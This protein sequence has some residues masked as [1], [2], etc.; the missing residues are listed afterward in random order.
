M[1]TGRVVLVCG[2]RG[3]DDRD[4]VF[5]VLDGLHASDPIGLLRHGDAP[6]ADALADEWARRRGVRRDPVP[7]EWDR[8]RRLDGKNPA[9]AIRNRVMLVREPRPVLVVAFPGGDGTADMVRQSRRAG[10]TVLEVS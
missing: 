1:N 8:Y 7:A 3:Y 2:G 4:R 5:R 9:G 10:A 6:G